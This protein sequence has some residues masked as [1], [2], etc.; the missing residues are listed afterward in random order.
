MQQSDALAIRVLIAN[1]FN[2]ECV[3]RW[4]YS[5]WSHLNQPYPMSTALE[6]QPTK[7]IRNQRYSA[8]FQEQ[9]FPNG[10]EKILLINEYSP[11]LHLADNLR[12]SKTIE[13]AKRSKNVV[14]AP[15]S[16]VSA[17]LK[18]KTEENRSGS[19]HIFKFSIDLNVFLRRY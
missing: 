18:Q 13:N 16:R 10:P 5:L 15:A 9:D 1:N 11:T 19:N 4:S 8:E 14:R 3:T 12:E 6:S 17:S 7:N 2:Y